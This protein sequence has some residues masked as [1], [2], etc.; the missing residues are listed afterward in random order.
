MEK[1]DLVFLRNGVSEE[2][3]NRIVTE[4][5]YD[6]IK[7]NELISV[8]H[9]TIVFLAG[10]P[11]SGKSTIC[12]HGIVNDEE[13]HY[14]V[15]S[16][17]DIKNEM[18]RRLNVD[19]SIAREWR[20]VYQDEAWR[21][22]KQIMYSLLRLSVNIVYD[23]TLGS[24]K[25][26]KEMMDFCI[27][28]EL[29]YTFELDVVYAELSELF[30][31]NSQRIGHYVPEESIQAIYGKIPRTISELLPYFERLTFWDNTVEIPAG[32]ENYE[33]TLADNIFLNVLFDMEEN[34]AVILDMKYEKLKEYMGNYMSL[35]TEHLD[36]YE[37]IFINE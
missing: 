6:F 21:I 30:R 11:N 14:I 7:S 31:R 23:S 3:Y 1:N 20:I 8:E 5:L 15:I 12:N 28:N 17:D 27:H 16:Q 9:P 32:D 13:K 4:L 10:A 29:N 22:T 24:I 36:S 2:I 37:Q 34:Q 18:Q 35:L 33:N 19:S 26:S 25:K